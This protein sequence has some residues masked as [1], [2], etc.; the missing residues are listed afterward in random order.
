[1]VEIT[2]EEQ[3]KG[4]R[5]KDSLRDLWDNVKHTNIWILGVPEDE[6]EKKGSEKI[7]EVIIVE[8]F[9]NMGREIVNQVQE[10]QSP[11]Q[12]KPKQKH[13]K[14]HTSQAS[15]DWTQRKTIKSS[16]RKATSHMQ[17]RPHVINS[18]S[19]GRNCRPEGNGWIWLTYWTEKMRL[20]RQASGNS[21]WKARS[22]I[23]LC[24]R[25]PQN[26]VN[27]WAI[28]LLFSLLFLKVSL[29]VFSCNFFSEG[30]WAGL[31]QK[32]QSL[33]C[34]V[35]ERGKLKWLGPLSSLA[36]TTPFPFLLPVAPPEQWLRTGK[37]VPRETGRG[38]WPHS[39]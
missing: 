4:K 14:T 27:V 17:R 11:I 13:A 15:K 21:S 2:A 37:P 25:S 22:T 26:I 39:S 9:P 29:G 12:D 35:S 16:K 10:V 23:F 20:W 30:G 36:P 7:F 19:F 6:E 18:W 34:A 28:I 1:M 31:I 38:H 8:N 3:N 24:T 33:L 32:T 5:I